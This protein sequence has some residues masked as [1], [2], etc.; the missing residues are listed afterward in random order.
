M[1][2]VLVN[3]LFSNPQCLRELPRRHIPLLQ[4]GRYLLA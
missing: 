1:R 4:Q 3:R 2:E